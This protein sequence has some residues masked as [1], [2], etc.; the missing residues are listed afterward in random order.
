MKKVL[1]YLSLILLFIFS[2]TLA[3]CDDEPAVTPGPDNGS[4]DSGTSSGDTTEAPHTHNFL[5]GYLYEDNPLY[6][7]QHQRYCDDCKQLVW[8]DHEYGEWKTTIP[9]TLFVKGLQTKYCECGHKVTQATEVTGTELVADTYITNLINSFEDKI[10]FTVSDVDI[11]FV[12]EG[13]DLEFVVSDV[14]LYVQLDEAGDIT[15]YFEGGAEVYLYGVCG[16]YDVEAVYEDGFAYATLNSGAFTIDAE[17]TNFADYESTINSGN[18]TCK[19]PAYNIYTNEIPMDEY[20]DEIEATLEDF[21]DEIDYLSKNLNPEVLGVCTNLA[22]KEIFDIAFV[23]TSEDGYCY[24]LNYE[25][26]VELSEKLNTKTLAELY[27]EC[28]GDGSFDELTTAISDMLDMTIGDLNDLV[29]EH[30]IDLK[31]AVDYIDKLI[32][33]EDEDASLK[34]YFEELTNEEIKDLIAYFSQ[35]GLKNTKV[36]DF[37]S[38]HITD[39]SEYTDAVLEQITGFGNMT[40]YEIIALTS[41]DY[42]D[43]EIKEMVDGFIDLFSAID[44][45]QILTTEEGTITKIDL[46]FD[47]SALESFGISG[48]AEA[49]IE[50]DFEAT[51]DTEELINRVDTMVARIAIDENTTLVK[52]PY[53]EESEF[54]DYEDEFVFDNDGNVIGYSRVT[55]ELNIITIEKDTTT[56]TI[57]AELETEEY[58]VDLSNAPILI[59]SNC[60]GFYDVRY[61]N[62]ATINSVNKLY[63]NVTMDED[64]FVLHDDADDLESYIYS[65]I[66]NVTPE[67]EGTNNY[68]A[69]TINYLYDCNT[70]T[71]MF[72]DHYGLDEEKHNYVKDETESIAGSECCDIVVD[73]YVC[74]ICGAIYLDISNYGHTGTITADFGEVEDCYSDLE[75]TYT[76]SDCGMTWVEYPYGHN[77]TMQE[78]EVFEDSV[79]S[80]GHFM[81]GSICACGAQYETDSDNLDTTM[82]YDEET[83]CMYCTECGIYIVYDFIMD[84]RV[85]WT[86]YT[87]EPGT[88]DPYLVLI[89]YLY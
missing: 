47:L 71:I 25:A 34:S 28:F 40:I 23:N 3:A 51:Y 17:Y 33:L 8:L 1:K 45:C 62:N 73:Y 49:Q 46:D 7:N 70:N 64:T 82:E 86:F 9:A 20:M 69:N 65:L 19:I 21:K 42:E 18:Y 88:V 27:E 30:D 22:L 15:A 67:Y 36:V 52:D 66:E 39:I 55:T 41:D 48:K 80:K 54:I 68:E 59:S 29:Q 56:V 26:L 37:I 11:A 6:E 13:F 43:S 75:V 77:A 74:S 78:I 4:T 87:A 58:F 57:S 85:S 16:V 84:Y 53:F 81:V 44:N 32:K 76:C 14:P 35:T 50:F 60:N 2:I 89:T 72:T 83:S 31:S 61:L 5:K 24:E 63:S 12:E 38:E 79:C 10:C